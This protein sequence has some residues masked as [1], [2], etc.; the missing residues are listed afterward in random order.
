MWLRN[1][2]YVA[3]W[4]SELS[5]EAIIARNV[6][7]Q[8]LVLYRKDD[9]TVVAMEDRCCH[10]LAPL[11][12]G[13]REGDDLRCMYHGLKFAPDGRCIE[14]PGQPSIPA[15]ARVRTFPVAERGAWIWIWMGEA[16]KADPATLPDSVAESDRGWRIAIGHLDYVADYQLINDN[17]LDLSHLSF[18]HE[19][20]LGRGMPHWAQERPR[21]VRLERG[22]RFQR[23]LRNVPAASFLK[24]HGPAVDI[25]HSYDFLVPG[26]FLQRTNYYAAGSAERFKLEPPGEGPL[27]SRLDEQAVTPMSATTARYFFAAGGRREE[28]GPELCERIFNHALRAFNEDKVMI[29]GQHRLIEREPDRPM[30]AVSFDA[31]P[32]LFRGLMKGLIDREQREAHAVAAE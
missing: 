25:W 4:S 8:A 15:K 16:D 31:G 1:C 30:V 3:A 17:L 32:N 13:R 26:I 11:S 10:R 9:G 19:N 2:W 24:Q 29:E 28:V 5:A 21:T 7:D 6:I 22:V 27:F 20:T 12:K 14:I 18:T 23:W